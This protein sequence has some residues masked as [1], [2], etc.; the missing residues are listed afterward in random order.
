MMDCGGGNREDPGGY[1]PDDLS[2]LIRVVKASGVSAERE[3][4]RFAD[5]LERIA[6]AWEKG[7]SGKAWN[8]ARRGRGIGVPKRP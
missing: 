6:N 7:G 1:P 2:K 8:D 4:R 3:L 5:A